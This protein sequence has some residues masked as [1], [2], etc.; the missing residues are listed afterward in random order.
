[1][2]AELEMTHELVTAQDLP[3]A[4]TGSLRGRVL[5]PGTAEYETTC[6]IYNDMINKSL[7]SF[8]SSCD[9]P[10][11]MGLL[12]KNC[13]CSQRMRSQSPIEAGQKTRRSMMSLSS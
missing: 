13:K 10:I 8:L 1:M 2:T 4:L 5:E 11:G 7:V 6:A 9:P 12:L 3:P